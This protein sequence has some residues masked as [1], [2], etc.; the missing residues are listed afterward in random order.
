[1]A[2][3]KGKGQAV[4]PPTLPTDAQLGRPAAACQGAEI[5][6]G[7]RGGH[8]SILVRLEGSR[9]RAYPGAT[10]ELARMSEFG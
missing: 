8:G 5:F 2:F 3:L 1:M 4:Y 10:N 7:S 9:A 6:Y